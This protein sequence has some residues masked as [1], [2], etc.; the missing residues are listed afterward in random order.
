MAKSGRSGVYDITVTAE[1]GAVV[2]VFR[3]RSRTIPAP[4]PAA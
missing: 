4:Q 1:D 2:A 3:G